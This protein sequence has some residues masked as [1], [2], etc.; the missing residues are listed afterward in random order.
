LDSRGAPGVNEPLR[1][2]AGGLLGAVADCGDCRRAAAVVARALKRRESADDTSPMA[3]VP[4]F[5]VQR[6]VQ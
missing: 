1:Y 5:V 6:A 3:L 2:T 4:G